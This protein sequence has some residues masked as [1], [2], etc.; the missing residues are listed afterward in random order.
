MHYGSS[1]LLPEVL[2]LTEFMWVPSSDGSRHFAWTKISAVKFSFAVLISPIFKNKTRMWTVTYGANNNHNT[3]L[4]CIFRVI[5][6]LGSSDPPLTAVDAKYI[7]RFNLLGTQQW[8]SDVRFI[9]LRRPPSTEPGLKRTCIL[10]EVNL[11]IFSRC[12]FQ[13]LVCTQSCLLN[14]P[15][16]LFRGE[17]TRDRRAF[18]FA[19]LDSGTHFRWKFVL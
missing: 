4:F 19:A 13:R 16:C 17:T 1:I 18:S 2:Q 7:D 15:I 11:T 14:L 3:T 10:K 6:S 5:E 12:W 9:S 8:C